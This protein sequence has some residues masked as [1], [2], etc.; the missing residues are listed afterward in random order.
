MCSRNEK[1]ELTRRCSFFFGGGADLDQIQVCRYR[2][3]H[4]S[5]CIRKCHG[6]HNLNCIVRELEQVSFKIHLA[7]VTTTVST[8]LDL[9]YI[10]SENEL[11]RLV[12]PDFSF[13]DHVQDE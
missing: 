7:R 8:N 5:S 9:V 10:C 3:F 2:G 13:L 6:A 11:Q 4:S 12:S 1:S